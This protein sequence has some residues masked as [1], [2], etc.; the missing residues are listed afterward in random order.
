VL[1]TDGVTWIPDHEH[2]GLESHEYDFFSGLPL[3]SYDFFDFRIGNAGHSV[4]IGSYTDGNSF[5]MNTLSA[6]QQVTVSAHTDSLTIWSYADFGSIEI[7]KNDVEVILPT[8]TNV[9]PAMQSTFD[10]ATTVSM[11]ESGMLVIGTFTIYLMFEF[12]LIIL[13]RRRRR[14]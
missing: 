9:F 3:L 2:A 7:C 6:G 1:Y 5:S 4:S 11:T 8:F 14:A 13:D 12:L 10:T